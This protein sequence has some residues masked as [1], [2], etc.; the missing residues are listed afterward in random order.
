MKWPLYLKFWTIDI[1]CDFGTM[2]QLYYSII[3][4]LSLKYAVQSDINDRHGILFFQIP[5]WR[6][7]IGH[8]PLL[9]EVGKR[10]YMWKKNVMNKKFGVISIQGRPNEDDLY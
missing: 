9:F 3:W 5:R 10:F 2:I 6:Y 4:Y 8:V 7:I 1:F